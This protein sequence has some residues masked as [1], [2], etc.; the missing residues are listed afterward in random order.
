MAG[1]T[2]HATIREVDVLRTWH[3]PPAYLQAF[4]V[5][6]HVNYLPKIEGIKTLL[7]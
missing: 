4:G 1:H 6:E 7:F 2:D 5:D 3:L